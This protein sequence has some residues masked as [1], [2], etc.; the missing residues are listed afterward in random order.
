MADFLSAEP[1]NR[2]P[3][4]PAVLLCL[5]FALPATAQEPVNIDFASRDAAVAFLQDIG[6]ASDYLTD[7]DGASHITLDVCVLSD[8][9][10]K[11]PNSNAR[12]F[13][14]GEGVRYHTDEDGCVTAH[15]NPDKKI[16]IKPDKNLDWVPWKDYVDNVTLG[17]T[18]PYKGRPVLYVPSKF[19]P[20]TEG[21]RIQ[22]RKVGRQILKQWNNAGLQTGPGDVDPVYQHSGRLP[23]WDRIQERPYAKEI[24]KAKYELILP[25]GVNPG[26]KEANIIETQIKDAL[27]ELNGTMFPRREYWLHKAVRN[28][29]VKPYEQVSPKPE[30]GIMRFAPLALFRNT[31]YTEGTLPGTVL[32]YNLG[33]IIWYEEHSTPEEP[34][35]RGYFYNRI[36][37]EVGHNLIPYHRT[38]H[39]GIMDGTGV[40]SNLKFTQL[41]YIDIMLGVR[42][43]SLPPQSY[44]NEGRP[45][46][47]IYGYILPKGPK[48]AARY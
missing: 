44:K 11:T 18:A 43:R 20:N 29:E 45:P 6:A 25:Q 16:K 9:D 47:R 19:D 38:D 13:Q 8:L 37:H 22:Q 7:P 3:G 1:P 41:D 21:N 14:L 5:V 48:P 34:H 36:Q 40:V 33:A 26:S 10:H 27:L 39:A 15:I 42:T 23:S 12:F 2:F 4:A 35:E 30:R 31:P 17:N 46:P 28:M 32:G 24:R